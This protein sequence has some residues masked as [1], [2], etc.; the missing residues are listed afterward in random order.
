MEQMNGIELH[1]VLIEKNLID[2]AGT[3]NA[4]KVNII[5]GLLYIISQELSSVMS[6]RS[7]M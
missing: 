5:S 3:V 2:E 4:F 6:P 1:S 7:I